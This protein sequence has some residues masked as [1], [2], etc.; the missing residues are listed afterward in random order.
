MKKAATTINVTVSECLS[1]DERQQTSSLLAYSSCML[2]ENSAEHDFSI[3][4]KSSFDGIVKK[5]GCD[6]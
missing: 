4:F 5:L 1:L 2:N 6:H 3:Y